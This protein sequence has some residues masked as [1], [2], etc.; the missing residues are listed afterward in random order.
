V[1]LFGGALLVITVGMLVMVAP[2]RSQLIDGKA[3][4]DREKLLAQAMTLQPPDP[5]A[6]R[7]AEADL[8]AAQQRLEKAEA[9]D[10]AYALLTPIFEVALSLPAVAAAELLMLTA[11]SRRARRLRRE[12]RAAETR[13][14]EALNA[15]EADATD[16]LVRFGHGQEALEAF[17][18]RV[19]RAQ[20]APASSAPQPGETP[21]TTPASGPAQ[22]PPSPSP[23]GSERPTTV[24]PNGPMG[25]D[26]LPGIP[27]WR[28]FA[29]SGQDTQPPSGRPS[30]IGLTPIP[31]QPGDAAVDPAVDQPGDS[32]WDESA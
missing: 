20:R 15:W 1:G 22:P 25:S 6:V 7:A 29:P 11:A 18:A 9:V 30:R 23:D 26:Q 14:G 12:A 5:L 13:A 24:R 28:T 16:K 19:N 17:L 10:R 8:T 32:E 27:T 3:V 21:S 31:D 4:T 2:A